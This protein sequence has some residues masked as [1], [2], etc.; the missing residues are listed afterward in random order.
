MSSFDAFPV[1]SETDAIVIRK[2][3]FCDARIEDPLGKRANFVSH[4]PIP[5]SKGREKAWADDLDSINRVRIEGLR[6][7]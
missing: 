2:C 3:S 7:S 4:H 1:V 5:I 6:R